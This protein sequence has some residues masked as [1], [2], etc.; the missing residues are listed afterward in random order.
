MIYDANTRELF[1]YDDIGP[2]WAGMIDAE[3]VKYSLAQLGPG[4]IALRINSYGG[5]VDEALAMI[6]VLGRHNGNVSVTIDSIA[7]SAASLFGAVFP[8]TIASHARVMIHNPWGFGFGN[9]AEM[10]KLAGVLDLYGESLI[11]VYARNMKHSPEEIKALMD[12]ETW[13]SAAQAVEAGLADS[14][15]E[16]EKKVEAKALAA[17]RFVHPPS[18][19]LAQP[20]QKEPVAVPKARIAASLAI[21]ARKLKRK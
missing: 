19:L 16:P 20:A 18:D 4:D 3:T 10:R 14:V 6:E 17:G 8:A 13:F 7:A 21:A 12:A 2:K 5:A 9:A 11:T 15:T 1:I